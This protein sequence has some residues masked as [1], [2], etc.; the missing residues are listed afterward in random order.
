MAK[1]TF[2]LI[3]SL[4][5][6]LAVL[7]LEAGI[8]GLAYLVFRWWYWLQ[9]FSDVLCLFGVMQLM[10]ASL[11]MMTR[12]YEVSDS[13]FGVPALPVQATEEE[14][15]WQAVATVIEQK[16]FAFTMIFCGLI[17]MVIAVVLSYLPR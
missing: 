8:L 17:T 9:H 15:H 11:G 3:F 4:R 14:K 1:R 5:K 6:V 7:A 12:P 13:P 10:A 16:S 2:F